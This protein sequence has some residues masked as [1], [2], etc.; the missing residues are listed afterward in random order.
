MRTSGV[1]LDTKKDKYCMIP[2]TWVPR[3]V[4][5]IETESI[6]WIFRVAGKGVKS[7]SFAR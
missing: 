3:V 5:F 7:F 4:K 2:L 1:K 6:M